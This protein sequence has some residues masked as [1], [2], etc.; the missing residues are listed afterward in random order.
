MHSVSNVEPKKYK[1]N[2]VEFQVILSV[3]WK[4]FEIFWLKASLL[5][6]N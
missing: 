6:I 4:N 1:K 2:I 5:K 3:Q